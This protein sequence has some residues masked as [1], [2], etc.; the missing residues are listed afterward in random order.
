MKHPRRMA[1]LDSRQLGAEKF[2]NR[3]IDPAAT[4]ECSWWCVVS[5]NHLIGASVALISQPVLYLGIVRDNPKPACVRE[6]VFSQKKRGRP[7]EES[8]RVELFS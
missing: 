4:T 2:L 7:G 3:W 5:A 6:H 8:A 1:C